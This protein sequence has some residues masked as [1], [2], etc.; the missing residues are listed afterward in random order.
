[1]EIPGAWRIISIEKSDNFLMRRE[2]FPHFK[3]RLSAVVLG[4]D[5]PDVISINTRHMMERLFIHL[6]HGSL[7]RD[8]V[9][10][11]WSSKSTAV[12]SIKISQKG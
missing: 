5:K 3:Q 2:N 1:L 6:W 10:R 9:G 11:S 7:W 12:L 4:N 8:R